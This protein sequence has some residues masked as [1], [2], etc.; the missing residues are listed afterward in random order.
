MIIKRNKIKEDRER[1]IVVLR[2]KVWRD[3]NIKEMRKVRESVNVKNKIKIKI[4]KK[5]V[6]SDEDNFFF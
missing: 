2:Q 5:K 4:F 3:E 6:Q 1:G